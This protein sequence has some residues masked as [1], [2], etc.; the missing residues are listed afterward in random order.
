MFCFSSPLSRYTL[1]TTVILDTAVLPL[2]HNMMADDMVQKFLGGLQSSSKVC[3]ICV[4]E[5]ELKLW[6]PDL[7][8]QNSR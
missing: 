2:F 1:P 8:A 6:K 7:G 4:T 3:T 5:K